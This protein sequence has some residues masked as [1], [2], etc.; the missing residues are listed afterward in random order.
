MFKTGDLVEEL[1]NG[2]IRIVGREK[3]V[4]NV[5]GEKVLPSE[6][7]SFLMQME[8][9][10]DALVRGEKNAITGQS[11]VADVVIIEG[12]ETKKAK[13]MIR[14]F[15]KKNMPMFKVPTKIN[16]LEQTNI[17]NRAKKVRLNRGLQ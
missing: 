11:V 16:F 3:E 17:S 8:I 13:S 14:L 15:C 1:E 4:I 12:L 2:Y 5:G 6:V 7:E 9:I 10:K